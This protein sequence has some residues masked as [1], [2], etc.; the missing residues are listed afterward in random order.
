MEAFEVIVLVIPPLILIGAGIV[1]VKARP[2]LRV[3]VMLAL[4]AVA[5]YLA[6]GLATGITRAR[7][8]SSHLY[9]FSKY[10]ACLNRL[11][12][13]ADMKGLRD[14]VIFFDQRYQ[15]DP[16]SPTNIQEIVCQIFEMWHRNSEATN[17]PNQTPQDT[18]LRV[19]PER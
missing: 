7:F 6:F 9:W 2:W 10:S 11:A 19:D 5:A 3:V 18:S 12:M 14:T 17:T 15:Q 8:N 4:T 16:Q 1:V 13:D